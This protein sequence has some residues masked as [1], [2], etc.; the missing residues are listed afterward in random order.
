MVSG[1]LDLHFGVPRSCGSV[2]PFA[3]LKVMPDDVEAIARLK[4][5][6]AKLNRDRDGLHS[7]LTR[8]LLDQ[9]ELQLEELEATAKTTS[10]AAFSCKRPARR[11]FP[12]HLPR[13]RIIMPAPETRACCGGSRLSKL[14]EDTSPRRWR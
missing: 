10:V 12:D 8:R 6:I 2:I 9:L 3:H 5:E 1:R 14:G 4:L 11:A 13:E 7:E